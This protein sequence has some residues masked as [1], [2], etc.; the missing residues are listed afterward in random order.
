[1]EGRASGVAEVTVI[2]PVA[3]VP[4][5]PIPLV[6]PAPV[7]PV[8]IPPVVQVAQAAPSPEPPQ[9][10]REI[11]AIALEPTPEL[12]AAESPTAIPAPTPAVTFVT[13][14]DS[15]TYRDLRD[16]LD[17]IQDGD[18]ALED[19]GEGGE[20]W[21]VLSRWKDSGRYVVGK[22]FYSDLY[23]RIRRRVR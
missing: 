22:T 21:S 12:I 5:T 23:V 1:M 3:V 17:T 10:P 18:E 2:A 6:K 20:K 11:P 8:V 4:S 13:E 14:S 7:Q 9:I 19:D 15:P 16:D